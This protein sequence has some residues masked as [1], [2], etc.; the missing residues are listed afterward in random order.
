MN[1][2]AD[3]V[4]DVHVSMIILKSSIG[5]N[6]VPH[7]QAALHSSYAD[8]ISH[9]PSYPWRPLWCEP[10]YPRSLQKTKP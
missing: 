3:G 7:P 10:H 2:N 5:T 9:E 6:V 4:S 8:H 1:W